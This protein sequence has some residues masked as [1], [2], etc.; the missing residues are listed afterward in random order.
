MNGQRWARA[1]HTSIA[2]AAVLALA[3]GCSQASPPAKETQL[4]AAL[5]VSG[6][7]DDRPLLALAHEGFKRA[8]AELAVEAG[9]IEAPDPEGQ[10]AAL[11]GA[12]DEGYAL[13]VCAG[14]DAEALLAVAGAFP[15]VQFGAVDA[16]FAEGATLPPNLSAVQITSHEASFL[17]GVVAGMLTQ[18]GTVGA[19]GGFD[20][21]GV[22]VSIAAYEQGV[23]AV[24]PGAK[25]FRG[26]AGGFANPEM[27]QEVAMAQY[28]EGA[29]IVYHVAGASGQGVFAAA[30]EADK[31]AIGVDY[32]QDALAEGHVIVSMVRRL[33]NVVYGFVEA[34]LEG[35][36]EGG[37]RTAG[38]PEDAA[39]VSWD[40]G[41]DVFAQHG[42][43]AL[44]S[45]LDAVKA[46][47]DAYRGKI[48]SG[49]VVVVNLLDE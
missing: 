15:D 7:L 44:V 22:N 38:V 18:S 47:V 46:E 25:V 20:F 17:V 5:V 45:Q 41:S 34:A 28:A 13:I 49:E 16:W 37:L 2:L 19:I 23:Q 12:V 1:L 32:N 31:Y 8:E 3:L 39:G 33:D 48:G 4:K 21:P 24:K 26:Y 6:P 9:V 43:E 35:T 42:P 10:E 11:R 14:I 40:I 36:F 29:D 30:Q 27:A